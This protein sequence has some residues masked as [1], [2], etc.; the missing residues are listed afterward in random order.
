MPPCQP[1]RQNERCSSRGD[2]AIQALRWRGSPDDRALALSAATAPAAAA[3]RARDRRARGVAAAPGIAIGPIFQ[4]RKET[5]SVA[6]GF[7]DVATETERLRTA[8]S[9]AQA[10]IKQLRDKMAAQAVAEA[11]IFDVH[12]DL[13]ADPDLLE[14]VHEAIAAQNNA[15]QAWQN[16][17]TTRAQVIAPRLP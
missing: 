12:L 5:V 1:N 16:S 6:S 10:E 11:A 8:V 13:L 3:R 2:R 9:Q 15:A 4:L 14:I 7:S 17:I